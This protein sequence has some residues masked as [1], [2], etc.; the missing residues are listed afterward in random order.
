[1]LEQS[2]TD[3]AADKDSG[4]GKERVRERDKERKKMLMNI[5]RQLCLAGTEIIL[6][7]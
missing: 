7:G 1:M 6:A 3:R 5:N 4:N 2:G